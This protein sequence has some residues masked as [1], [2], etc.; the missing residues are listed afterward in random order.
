MNDRKRQVLLTAQRLFIEKG[1]S[2]TSVQD[3][4]DES[5]IS[6]GTFYN[7]FSSKNECLIA[8]LE[9]AHDEATVRRRELLIG[10][11]LSDKNDFG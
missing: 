3:I 1:F 8:I 10:Q 11:D 6:K 4:L 7:Y 2:T 5:C 9:H